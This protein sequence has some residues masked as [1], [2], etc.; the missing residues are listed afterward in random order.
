MLKL[1]HKATRNERGFTLIELLVVVVILGVLATVAIPR[2]LGAIERARESKAVA[3]IRVI[4]SGLERYYFDHGVYPTHLGLLRGEY[5][6]SDFD[7]K[8]SYGHIYFYAVK[9][10]VVGAVNQPDHLRQFALGDP[11]N[12]PGEFA[13][14]N[15]TWDGQGAR[16]DLPQGRAPEDTAYWWGNGGPTEVPSIGPNKPTRPDLQYD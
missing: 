14:T 5:L 3:D 6:K 12:P 1:I 2:V 10:N 11:T 4:V 13:G 9:W 7:F 15:W 8:N 16:P